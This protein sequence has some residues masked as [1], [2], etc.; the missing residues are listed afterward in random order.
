MISAVFAYFSQLSPGLQVIA[1][2]APNA[3]IPAAN[4]MCLCFE[5]THG[6]SVLP[7]N[8]FLD[9]SLKVGDGGLIEV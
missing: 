1:V 7:M 5:W 8:M 2:N 4:T 9:L 6:G 3:S